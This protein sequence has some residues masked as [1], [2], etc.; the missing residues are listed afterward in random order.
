MAELYVQNQ[1]AF[2]CFNLSGHD[3]LAEGFRKRTSGEEFEYIGGAITPFTDCVPDIGGA[4][5]F[6]RGLAAPHS[7]QIILQGH[8]LGCDR[9]IHFLA[10][11]GNAYDLIL[12]APCDSSRLQER[13][14]SP[15]TMEGQIERLRRDA[16]HT[17][18]RLLWKEYGIRQGGETYSI[19]ILRSA[20]LN[21]LEGPLF[22]IIRVGEPVEWRLDTRCAIY[23]GGS[24]ELQTFDPETMFAFFEA[25]VRNLTRIFIPNGDHELRRCEIAVT[26]AL[27]AWMGT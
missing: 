2:F 5:R 25:R 17:E 21:L 7:P 3:G 19:P 9:V 23:L 18:D 10:T 14:I 24:D 12:L 20:L 8:S 6:V 11:T 22:K 4:I 15:E 16:V 27:L 26:A 13:W 1:V